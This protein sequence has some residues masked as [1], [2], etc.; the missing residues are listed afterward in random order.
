MNYKQDDAVPLHTFGNSRLACSGVGLERADLQKM[1]TNDRIR[2]R[3]LHLLLCNLLQTHNV[4][5][6]RSTL[7]VAMQL[8]HAAVARQRRR[9]NI[10]GGALHL[11]ERPRARETLLIWG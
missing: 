5:F 9:E 7:R 2:S 8:V 6:L 1:F 4:L 10:H 3:P 11:L